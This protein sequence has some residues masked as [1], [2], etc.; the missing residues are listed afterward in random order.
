MCSLFP[1]AIFLTFVVVW[2]VGVW[3]VSTD[4]ESINHM[5]ICRNL[6]GNHITKTRLFKYIENFTSKN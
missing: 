2:F 4:P 5:P 1:K 6:A 3:G